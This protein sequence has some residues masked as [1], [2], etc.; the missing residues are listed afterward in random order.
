MR[1]IKVAD[2]MIIKEVVTVENGE[3]IYNYYA[4]DNYSFG[5]CHRLA[6][7]HIHRLYKYGYF[8]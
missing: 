5:V 7:Q 1:Q 2:D 8:N 6:P 3:K 4:N